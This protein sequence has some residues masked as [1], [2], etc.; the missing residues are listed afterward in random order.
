MREKADYRDI[1]ETILSANDGKP[2]ISQKKAAEILGLCPRTVKKRYG[3]D[4]NGVSAATLAR[5][6]CG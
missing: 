3:V 2:L 6:L 4:K 5:R 1:L